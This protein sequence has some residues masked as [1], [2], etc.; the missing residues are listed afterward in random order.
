M[1]KKYDVGGLVLRRA[2]RGCGNG[3]EHIGLDI[4]DPYRSPPT[5]DRYRAISGKQVEYIDRVLDILSHY[6]AVS[7][8]EPE[9]HAY[10]YYGSCAVF[11]WA[12]CTCLR[13]LGEV[14]FRMGVLRREA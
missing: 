11:L 2:Y 3:V 8:H 6:W 13:V 5:D 4:K 14:G 7:L 1:K 9:L 12:G 10:N